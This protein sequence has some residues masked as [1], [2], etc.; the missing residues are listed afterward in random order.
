MSKSSK[1]G[2]SGVSAEE[3]EQLKLLSMLRA[4][5]ADL[6]KAQNEY[7]AALKSGNTALQGY[8]KGSMQD[9]ERMRDRLSDIID[10]TDQSTYAYQRF[11]KILYD[12]LELQ[13]K[14]ADTVAK[15]NR[16]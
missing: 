8:W 13:T 6:T 7:V 5:T 3:R 15:V 16:E 11:N 12:S 14:H 2:K 4:Y 10:Q 9:A 1:S